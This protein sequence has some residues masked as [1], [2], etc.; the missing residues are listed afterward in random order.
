MTN[1]TPTSRRGTPYIIA[2]YIALLLYFVTCRYWFLGVYI[3]SLFEDR[4]VE[5]AQFYLLAATV[6]LCLQT[7]K[8]VW[9]KE[10]RRA[11]CYVLAGVCCALVAGEEISWGQRIVGFESPWFFQHYNAQGETDL[12]NVIGELLAKVV[13]YE[14]VLALF[15]LGYGVALPMIASFVSVRPTAYR[16]ERLDLRCSAAWRQRRCRRD[17]R[18]GWSVSGSGGVAA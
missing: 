8:A 10:R 3:R 5:W 17:E 9:N 15:A 6:V 1:R 11:Y 18:S 13:D 2:S 14:D 7:A 12:H 16:A 4:Y